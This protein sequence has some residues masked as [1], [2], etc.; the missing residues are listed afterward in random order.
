LTPGTPIKKIQPTTNVEK[1][2][3]KEFVDQTEA[4]TWDDIEVLNKLGSGASASVKRVQ[5]KK[6]KKIFAM[7]TIA[8]DKK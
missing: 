7:K 8:I 5:H 3:E 2:K 4:I 1:E 6:T